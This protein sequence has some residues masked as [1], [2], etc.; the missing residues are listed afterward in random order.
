M[1]PPPS[2][3]V[4]VVG[5]GNAA[6][7]AALS[8]REHGAS[9]LIVEAAPENERG[10]NSAFHGGIF[11]FAFDTV[12]DLL[13]VCPD[14]S[15]HELDTI[16]FGS[17]PSSQYYEDLARLSGY[18][19]DPDLIALIADESFSA[20]RWLYTQGVR[21][22]P[23]TGRQTF[24]VEGKQ[25]VWGGVGLI[26]S[27]GGAGEIERL[28]RRVAEESID[29]WYDT[30]AR[31]LVSDA[32]GVH[33]VLVHRGKETIEISCKSVVLACGGFEANAEMRARYLGV[34]WDA[35]HVRGSR[36]NTGRGLQMALDAGAASCGL[37]SA[38]H[39]AATDL[40]TPPFGDYKLGDRFQRHNFPMGILVNR[41]GKRFVDEGSGIQSYIYSRAGDWIIQQ[42][43]N[44]AYQVFD[45][46][47]VPMLRDEYRTREATRIE[48]DTLDGLA[49]KL[50]QIDAQQFVETVREFNE[51]V[52]VT[53]EFDPNGLDGRGTRGLAINK[54]NWA[55]PL[56]APPFVAFPV[57]AGITFT[58]GGIRVD[59]SAQVQSTVGQAIDG[60]YA[61]GEMV[62][63]LY[64]DNYAGGTGSVSGAVFGRIAGREAAL[65][66]Q[67][68]R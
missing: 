35:A 32:A 9:V 10:G 24:R 41:D 27:G 65:S 30:E 16:D 3:D 54:S 37:W 26:M 59:T 68:G 64:Y 39:A 11:R 5:A 12:D 17:Y 62:G 15:Q 61:A 2:Y 49:A 57:T 53:K 4:V 6:L 22:Q 23:S 25:K 63:G 29:V 55:N 14:I 48:A 44:I 1:T 19:A 52:D 31:S 46:R 47:V 7:C 42:P 8:A 13:Q 18:K 56:D 36:F 43:G 40:N 20:A 60:L 58:F 45:Q 38:K 21:F 66:A 50:P 28:F 67:K 33:G 34:G 51:A